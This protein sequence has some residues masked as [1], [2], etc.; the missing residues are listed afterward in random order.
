MLELLLDEHIS[1]EVADGIKRRHRSLV[2]CVE[3]C[4][5]GGGTQVSTASES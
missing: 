3:I 4:G 5:G 2:G 1:P